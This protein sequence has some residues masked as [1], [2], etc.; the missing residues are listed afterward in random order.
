[1]KKMQVYGDVLLILNVVINFIIFVLTGWITRQK[2]CWWRFF[3][4]SFMGGIYVLGEGFFEIAILYTGIA[5]VT[6]SALLALIAFSYSNLGNFIFIMGVFYIVS[7]LLGGAV[8]GW[9]FLWEKAFSSFEYG[10]LFT[11]NYTQLFW[12]IG[13]GSVLLFFVIRRIMYQQFSSQTHYKIKIQ[14]VNQVVEFGAILDTGNRLYTPITCTPVV[15]VERNAVAPILNQQIHDFFENYPSSE[16][17]INLEKCPDTN[18]LERIQV[19]PYRGVGTDSMLLGFRPD[20]MF[21]VREKQDIKI[22][23]I[24]VAI[25]DG[26]LAG[27]KSYSALLHPQVIKKLNQSGEVFLCA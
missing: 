4:A 14:Y 20:A 12:G 7:F 5:K 21:V 9:T 18:W 11:L 1:M 15:I 19:I 24:V 10:A 2:Y 3:L 8:L 16:W 22:D 27:D 25:Y 13:I 6:V 26:A 23:D 17:V